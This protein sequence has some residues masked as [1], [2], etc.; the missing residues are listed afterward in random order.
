METP[1]SLFAAMKPLEEKGAGDVKKV[2]N[3]GVLE[4]ILGK[5]A[6]ASGTETSERC[7]L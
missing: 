5:F 2:G 7:S 6:K 1:N 3:S 4:A